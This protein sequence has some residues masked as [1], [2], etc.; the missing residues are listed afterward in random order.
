MCL[1][2]QTFAVLTSWFQPSDGGSTVL[3][4]TYLALHKHSI[5]NLGIVCHAA[6]AYEAFVYSLGRTILIIILRSMFVLVE[7][8]CW[9]FTNV[10]FKHKTKSLCCHFEEHDRFTSILHCCIEVNIE[11]SLK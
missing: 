10:F 5:D 3:K 8:Y 2:N 9:H 7:N 4:G 11:L 6:T 1:S